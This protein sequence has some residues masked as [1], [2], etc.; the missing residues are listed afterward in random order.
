[1]QIS[2]KDLWELCLK[3]DKEAFKEIYCRFYSQL[4]NYGV[5]L[6]SDKD[7]VKDCIQDIFIKL[8]QNYQSLSTTPNVKGYL[9]KALRNKLYDTLGKEKATDDISLYEEVFVTDELMPLLS[10]DESEA[11]NQAKQL[12][13]V[14]SQLSSHQQEIIYLYYVNELKHDEIAEI[15]GINYQ[16]SKNLLFRSLSSLRKL[17]QKKVST[18]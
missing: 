2:D 6:V 1:M 8:I 3:G 11:D 18:K 4:Y 9:I 14:F 13:H 16:S 12:M 17:Y 7:L 5:K 10:F 15:M